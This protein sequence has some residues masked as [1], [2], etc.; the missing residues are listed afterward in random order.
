MHQPHAPASKFASRKIA[1]SVVM[2]LA[3]CAAFLLAAR[4]AAAPLNSQD[5]R[6]KPLSI[7]CDSTP[8]GMSLFRLWSNGDIEVMQLGM[9]NI[10]TEWKGVAPGKNG[11]SPPNKQS[12]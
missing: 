1:I 2:A 12:Q 10:W 5:A 8:L 6:G 4:P 11:S 3:G 7:S 9:D